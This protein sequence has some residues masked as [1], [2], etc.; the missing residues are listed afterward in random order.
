MG[1]PTQVL[2]GATYDARLQLTHVLREGGTPGQ[3]HHSSTGSDRA[4]MMELHEGTAVSA[5]NTDTSG[6]RSS[7]RELSL[8]LAMARAPHAHTPTPSN[9]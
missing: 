7:A 6:Q 9:P 4:A 5:H 1:V 8:R 2:S 3:S